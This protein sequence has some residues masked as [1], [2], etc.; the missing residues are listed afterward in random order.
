VGR[1]V[2]ALR[3]EPLE[4]G[5]HGPVVRGDDVPARLGLPGDAGCV[6]AEQVGRRRVLG[7]PYALLLRRREITG[8]ALHALRAQPEPATAGLDEPEYVG[9]REL[10]QLALR[11]LTLVWR[12][13]RDVDEPRNAIIR[14]RWRD[15]ASAVGVADKDRGAADPPERSE[16]GLDIPLVSVETVLDRGR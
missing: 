6:P 3:Q 16:G 10:L 1:R 4:I 15:D 7:R 5:L 11:G 13:R 9:S 12:K 8:E 2:H 14:P